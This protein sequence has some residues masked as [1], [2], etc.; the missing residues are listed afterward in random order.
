MDRAGKGITQVRLDHH[1]LPVELADSAKPFWDWA[2]RE[3]HHRL[4]KQ[5]FWGYP[6]D[7]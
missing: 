4:S 6:W 1:N 3:L 5:P 2:L 7:R